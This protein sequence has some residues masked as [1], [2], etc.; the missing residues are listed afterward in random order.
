MSEEAKK[1]EEVAKKEEVKEEPPEKVTLEPDVYNA[2]LDRLEEL[3][4]REAKGERGKSKTVD[5]LAAELEE[6]QAP[7]RQQ[8]VDPDQINNLSNSDLAR[9]ILNEVQQNIAQPLLVKL[10]EMRVSSEI[11]ELRKSLGE[12]DD[13]DDLKDDIYKVASRNPNLSIKEAY[14]LAKKEDTAKGKDKGENAEDKAERK[15]PLLRLPP[16]AHSEKPTQARSA[17]DKGH[18]ETRADAAKLAMDEMEKEGKLK[19]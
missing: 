10:E 6:R 7:R 19:F 5:E 1:E 13:F 17:T 18:P 2:L 3:E 12:N 15:A 11:Q 16:R 8:Q 9:L 4:G 14:K